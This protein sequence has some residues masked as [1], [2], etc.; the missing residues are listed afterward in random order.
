MQLVTS[1]C[2]LLLA[3]WGHMCMQPDPAHCT[4][5]AQLLCLRAQMHSDAGRHCSTRPPRG[6]QFLLHLKVMQASPAL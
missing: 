5:I 4:C 2:V 6:C 1:V 3:I